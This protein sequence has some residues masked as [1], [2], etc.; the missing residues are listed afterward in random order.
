MRLTHRAIEALR[1][2]RG[3]SISLFITDRCQVG[4]GHCSVDSR[5]DSPTIENFD[6]FAKILDWIARQPELEVVSIT[7]GEPFVE[8]RGLALTTRRLGAA[9]K[10]LA[11]YTSGV[12]GFGARIP[13]WIHDVL[14]R[15]DCVYLSTDA[16]HAE[17]IDDASLIN[18]AREI[19]AAEAWLVLQVLDVE[20]AREQAGELLNRAFGGRWDQHAEINVVSP[21]RYGRGESLVIPSTPVEG[22]SFG[23]CPLLQSPVIRYDGAISACSNDGVIM[24]LGP[25]RLR[26]RGRSPAEL[27]DVL[28]VLQ[29]D[30]ALRV[31]GDAGFCALTRHSKL[32]DLAEQSF[33][34]NCELCWKALDR[35][36]SGRDP[37]LDAL[38]TPTIDEDP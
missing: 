35:L 36:P 16:Y 8:R 23:P 34:T 1:R 31:I 13:G 24:G 7:G 4:C 2:E 38:T 19:A 22:R 37:E 27:D 26:R 33:S 9:G 17:I 21:V 28:A 6:R 3:R 18:A 5:A 15:C 14:A 20:P 12:W 32:R 30:P 25:A 10:L 29:A 11:V